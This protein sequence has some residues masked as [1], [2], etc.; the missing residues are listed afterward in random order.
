MTGETLLNGKL[1]GASGIFTAPAAPLTQSTS[2]AATFSVVSGSELV[3]PIGTYEATVSY[4]ENWDGSR[5]NHELLKSTGTGSLLD[6]STV[7][8]LDA[9]FNDSDG[10]AVTPTRSSPRTGAQSICPSVTHITN[11][12]RSRRLPPFRDLGREYRSLRAGDDRSNG[13]R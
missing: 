1:V 3:V 9:S 13:N 10:N 8:T 7:E 4:R 11:P 12:H 5:Y 6:L 2:G